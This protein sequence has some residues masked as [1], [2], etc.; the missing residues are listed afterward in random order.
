M[1]I[2]L[3]P[4]TEAPTAEA[5][6]EM[7]RA[8]KAR[9][10]GR[11]ASLPLVLVVAFLVLV[12]AGFILLASV[13]SDVP[14]P[15]NFTF[16]LTLRNFKVLAEGG[17]LGAAGNSV[18]MAA[19]AT[20]LAL[21]IGGTLAFICARTD[22]PL[23]RLVFLSGMMPLFLPSYV[24][25]LSWAVLG[26]PGS[27]LLNVAFHDL[28]LGVRVDVYSL[29][30]VTMVMAM[31]Y[32]P[33]AF[34][35]IHGAM[36]LMNP[37]LEDAAGVH[38]GSTWRT[39]RSVTVPLA[40]PAILGSGLLIFIHVLE[41][42]PVAQ[43]LATP[44]QIDTLPT[45]IYRLINTTPSRGNEAAVVSVVLVAAVVV[46]T[47]VQRRI[48]ARRSYTTVSGKGV[49]ARVL[50]LGALRLPAL[51]LAF[52]YFMMSMVLPLSA[53]LLTAVRTSPYM[54]SFSALGR[55]G[56]V[57]FSSFAQALTS[58]VFAKA[59]ANSVI[60]AVAAALA[61]TA[62]AFILGYT[63]YRTKLS[64]RGT[65][66][67]ISMVPL[68]IPAVVLGIGLLWTWLVMPI[69][70]YGTLW[71]LVI[72][73]VAIQLPQGFR[74]IAAAIQA[75]DRDLED[76]AV[77]LG[78]RRLRAVSAVTVPLL[79]VSISST[80]LLLMMLS[81]R[82]ITV[83]LFLYTNDTRILSIAIYDQ[84]ENGGALRSAAALALMYC[85]LMFALSLLPRLL[86]ARGGASRL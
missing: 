84:F 49:K 53:L 42:F 71:V 13:S 4:A 76:S 26:S 3:D 17:L 43:V 62:L 70:V 9:S 67:A 57:D 40:L 1:S 44:G 66:E 18:V 82:E 56:A 25:A 24:G 52:A 7:P 12:P 78:A 69:P 29:P 85:L 35:L 20:V 47:L 32:A 65:L 63:V 48:L 45:F 15:G 21:L 2:V 77:L 14:R 31:Y 80:F 37:D 33:Y 83:P 75:T 22:T 68:A 60:V 23:R 5:A 34:L 64:A 59:T 54:Q 74:G 72:G 81:M 51:A 58:D 73:F 38:G 10:K 30:G 28:G 27:G 55:A 79:R 39:V 41:N 11:F 50:P 46:M 86:G 36:S 61:G 6:R 16:S 8:G 19:G